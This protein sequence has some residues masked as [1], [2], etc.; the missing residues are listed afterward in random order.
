MTLPRVEILHGP[1]LNLLGEREPEVYGQTSLADLDA[2]LVRDGAALGVEVACAQSN[3]E[4]A[5]VD[6]VQE[7]RH[8]AAALIV[9]LGAYTHTSVALRD[10]VAAV[11]TRLVVIEV[12]LTAPSGREW[13]RRENLFADLVHGRIEGFGPLSYVLALRAASE[14][15]R[16]RGDVRD[17]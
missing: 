14:L 7:A 13:F 11:R 8:R 12:H 16:A 1:N 3:H 10:A 4:G 9:N 17:Q 2:R 15:I 6:A 5:L